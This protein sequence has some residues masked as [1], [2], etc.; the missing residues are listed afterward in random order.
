MLLLMF[1]ETCDLC[2]DVLELIF[3]IVGS[4]HLSCSWLTCHALSSFSY[5]CAVGLLLLFAD[6]D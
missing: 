2:Y 1:L 5:H 4:A 6:V 3:D